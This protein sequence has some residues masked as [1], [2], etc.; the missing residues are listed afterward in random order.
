LSDRRQPD[1]AILYGMS[2]QLESRRLYVADLARRLFEMESGQLP[3]QPLVYRVLSKRLR[4][5]LAGLPKPSA[6]AG[7]PELPPHLLRL[8]AE[9]LETRHF[10]DYGCLFGVCAARCRNQAESLVGRARRV[11]AS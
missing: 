1:G 8:V 2:Y 9:T 10:D 6:P 7:F 4:E 11:Q 5:A 3:M